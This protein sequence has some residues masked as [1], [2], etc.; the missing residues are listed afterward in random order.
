MLATYDS[1][2]SR[3]LGL[4]THGQ[5]TA[6]L[7]WTQ[8]QIDW[9]VTTGVLFRVRRGVYRTSGA[10]V[11]RSQVWLAA[12]MAAGDATVLADLTAVAF[13]GFRGYP[14]PDRIHLLAEGSSRTRLDG[15]VGHRTI[16]LPATHVMTKGPLRV[17][18]P[19]RTLV[20]TCG[21]VRPSTLKSA[22]RDAIR[23]RIMTPAAFVDC[24]ASVPRS[25]RRK[26][27]PAT[28]L[29]D[30]LG[31]RLDPGESDGEVD[32]V[33]TLVEAGY[34]I[35]DQQI[36]VRDPSWKYRI[37]VG[38]RCVKQ[39]FE[40]LGK[41]D[42]LNDFAFFDDP[43]RTMRLQRAGWQLWPVTSRTARDEILLAADFAFGHL[44]RR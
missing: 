7:G 9:A 39:G 6:Q 16:H 23:R 41:T 12:Q 26:R 35:P 38:Y 40:F 8:R 31:L 27:K 11:T 43:L 29:A 13:W 28:A 25:G 22:G 32:I 17:T 5:L 34:P 15:V 30:S 19:A 33:E 18:T 44:R 3:Q 14:P 21:Q 2:A 4:L 1:V 42:H 36:W 10:P 37:D 20:D 24:L